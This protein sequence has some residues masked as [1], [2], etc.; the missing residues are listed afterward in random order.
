ME[1]AL[2]S[3]IS[4]ILVAQPLLFES[5]PLD[6]RETRDSRLLRLLLSFLLVLLQVLLKGFGF[7]KGVLDDFFLAGPPLWKVEF[8]FAQQ[9]VLFLFEALV[10]FDFEGIASAKEFRPRLVAVL[11]VRYDVLTVGMGAVQWWV[12]GNKVGLLGGELWNESIGLSVK[13]F[14][15]VDIN[16]LAS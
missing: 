14:T 3:D 6:Q 2:E 13:R 10:E 9:A 11:V 8:E 15:S 5:T 4:I 12:H 1:S 16:T 7:S